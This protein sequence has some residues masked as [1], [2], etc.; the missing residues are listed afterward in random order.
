MEQKFQ[1]DSSKRELS[2]SNVF[3]ASR[4]KYIYG[5]SK[6]SAKK[7]KKTKYLYQLKR[8]KLKLDKL[9]RKKLKSKSNSGNDKIGDQGLRKEENVSDTDSNDSDDNDDSDVSFSDIMNFTD[10]SSKDENKTG[11]KTDEKE[12]GEEREKGTTDDIN[13]K[14]QLDED[15]M[16]Y[17]KIVNEIESLQN[18]L[19]NDASELKRNKTGKSYSPDELLSLIYNVPPPIPIPD[20]SKLPELPSS[21]MLEA[22]HYYIS[23]R[24]FKDP[25]VLSIKDHQLGKV[26][27]SF[28]ESALIMFGI[29]MQHWIDQIANETPETYQMYAKKDFIYNNKYRYGPADDNDDDD[30]D[31]NQEGD[32]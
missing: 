11:M 17:E 16:N 18:E 3:N 5:S 10:K 2:N 29:L 15:E 12:E 32:G 21:E 6:F 13:R 24:I 8:K 20:R 4:G 23:D 1:M 19:K 7:F 25:R 22:L 31:N 9:R 30:D 26:L 14:E 28:D 27:H